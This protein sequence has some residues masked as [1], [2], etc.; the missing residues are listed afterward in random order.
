MPV[1]AIAINDRNQGS[2]GFPSSVAENRRAG[3]H[4]M[5]LPLNNLRKSACNWIVT[6]FIFQSHGLATH[7]WF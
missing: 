5:G 1:T 2:M 7:Y 3:F 4:A 6:F